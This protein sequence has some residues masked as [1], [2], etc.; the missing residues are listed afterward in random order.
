MTD[1]AAHTPPTR[2]F[3]REDMQAFP[4]TD[5][6]DV[7]VVGSGAG[8]SPL[9]ARIAAGGLTVVVLEAG[10][11]WKPGDDFAADELAQTPLAWSDERLSAGDDPIALGRANSGTGVGGSTLIFGGCVPRALPADF[12]LNRDLGVGGDWPVGY[13]DLEPYCDEVEQILG[14][15]GP[16]P[17]PWGPARQPYPLAPLPLNGPAQLMQRA[18]ESMGLRASP[19]PSAALSRDYQRDEIGWRRACNNR[20]LCQSGCNRGSMGSMDATFVP[21]AISAGAEVRARC[22][23]TGIETEDHGRVGAVV[24]RRGKAEHRQRCRALFLCAGAIETPR[25]LLMSGLANEDGQVGRNLT[26]QTSLQL[27]GRFEAGVRPYKGIPAATIS[28]D[29]HRPQGA[30][31]AGGYLVHSL[32]V[33]PV[34]YAGQLARQRGLWGADLRRHMDAYNH[35]AGIAMLGDCL[36]GPGNRVELSEEADTRG[37]PKPR[38]HFTGGQN[39]TRLL[40]HGEATLRNIWSQAGAKDVWAARGPS[41]LAGTCRMGARATDAVVDGD[42]RAFGLANLYVCDASIL[43]SALSVGPALTIMALALRIADRFLEAARTSQ[44]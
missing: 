38:I 6:V 28:Q 17:Y 44:T 20:G 37:L 23:V 18:C 1:S 26:A 2:R 22:F 15:S 30:D 42:G 11:F 13:A 8:G 5:T 39:E 10:G 36:A 9:A 31:F 34:A 27:W 19:S 16:S 40:A 3:R 14:V 25:L 33:T 12:T 41:Y 7:V 32:G 43:P 21:M 24:Y 35:V 29:M 4:A